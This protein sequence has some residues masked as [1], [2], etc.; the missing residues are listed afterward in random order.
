MSYGKAVDSGSANVFT[1]ALFK[2]LMAGRYADLGLEAWVLRPWT[3]VAATGEATPLN[4]RLDP[5]MILEFTFRVYEDAEKQEKVKYFITREKE[6]TKLS[7]SVGNFG[8]MPEQEQCYPGA[9]QA[10]NLSLPKIQE[11]AEDLETG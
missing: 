8:D 10:W 7:V 6:N 4:K 9:K 1:K 5:M 2:Y 3:M 11:I